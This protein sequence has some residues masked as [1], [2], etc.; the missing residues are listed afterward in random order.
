MKVGNRTIL[1][2]E[3]LF[4]QD[5]ETVEIEHEICE[6]DT[7]NIRLIFPQDLEHEG[8]KNPVILYQS[9]G[10]WFELKFANFT[11]QLGATTNSPSIFAL[12]NKGEPISYMAAVYKLKAATKIEL[13]V[14]MEVAS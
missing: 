12:S 6:G 13:Q 2:S 11:S 14:M 5:G 10:D 3:T 4:V 9:I 1:I 7:L 8:A